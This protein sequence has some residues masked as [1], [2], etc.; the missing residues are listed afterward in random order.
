MKNAFLAAFL[1]ALATTGFTQTMDLLDPVDPATEQGVKAFTKEYQNLYNQHDAHALAAFFDEE[2][3]WNTPE[4]Q[5][6]GRP[7]IEQRLASFHFERWHAR[8]EV[9][10]VN[11]V[12]GLGSSVIMVGSWT[13]TVQETGGQP[14]SLHGFFNTLLA[15]DGN[16]WIIKLNSYELDQ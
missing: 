15:K 8:D 10:T 14:I 16:H 11:E 1:F 7:V 6:I 2:A 12:K 4:G 5:F 9:I 3:V 13:N